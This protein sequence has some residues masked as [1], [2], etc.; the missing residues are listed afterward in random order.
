MPS[1]N[2][3]FDGTPYAQ[4]TLPRSASIPDETLHRRCFAQ[5][6][7]ATASARH[8]SAQSARKASSPRAPMQTN[9]DPECASPAS[10]QHA[11][12]APQRDGL[13]QSPHLHPELPAPTP[14]RNQS[15][16]QSQS[17]HLQK[18]FSY[19]SSSDSARASAESAPKS[20]YLCTDYRP[21][22]TDNTKKTTTTVI[23]A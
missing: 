5:N 21:Q 18:R 13:A 22:T 6:D 15:A 23:V 3:S 9:N 11:Q 1:T 2:Q 7:L 10:A 20:I 16:H 14:D 4:S 19:S 8:S 17:A 12:T